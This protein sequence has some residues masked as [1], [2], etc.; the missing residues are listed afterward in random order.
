MLAQVH[1]VASR[2]VA[3]S[4]A[5]LL[6]IGVVLGGAVLAAAHT[7]SHVLIFTKTT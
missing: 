1:H 2:L 5:A 6:I 7:G 4:L 3:G